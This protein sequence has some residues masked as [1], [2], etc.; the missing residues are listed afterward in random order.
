[1]FSRHV[2][3]M[4]LSPSIDETASSIRFATSV[5]ISSGVAPTQVV[6]M[7]TY[8]TSAEGR[9]SSDSFL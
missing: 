5:S 9:F 8:G 7:L 2:V 4:C 1:M 3:W 6:L